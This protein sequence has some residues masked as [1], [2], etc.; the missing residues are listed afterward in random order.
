MSGVTFR[1]ETAGD[2]PRTVLRLTGLPD[3]MTARALL[4][5]RAREEASLAHPA[6]AEPADWRTQASLAERAFLSNAFFILTPTHQIDDL[7]EV[8]DLTTTPTLTFLRLI[9]LAGG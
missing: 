7:D 9:P 3:R 4:H 6:N 8:I 1:D 5:L 2:K